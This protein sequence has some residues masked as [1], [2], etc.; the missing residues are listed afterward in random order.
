M[1]AKPPHVTATGLAALCASGEAP[2]LVDVRTPW[3]F[4]GSSIA[5]ATSLPLDQ[6]DAKLFVEKQGLHKPCVVLCRSGM[7]A[8]NA[9]QQLAAAGM[10]NARVL[11]GGMLAWEAAG[12]PVQRIERQ[13]LS[14]ERQARIAN[15]LWILL[16][17]A[18]GT[19]VHPAWFTLCAFMGLSLVFSGLANYCGHARILA[20]APWNRAR[21]DKSQSN[22]TRKIA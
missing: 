11:E 2:L 13:P 1:H 4:R 8:S 16:G 17:W 10:T 12:L 14:L 5:G 7:R 18:L 3:E 21:P 6:L 15:G 19:G 9:A 22:D 20:M